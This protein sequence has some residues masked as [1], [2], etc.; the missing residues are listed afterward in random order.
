[1]AECMQLHYTRVPAVFFG[2]RPVF[3]ERTRLL[4]CA[5]GGLVMAW[6][7]GLEA[8]FVIVRG[9]EVDQ[10]V[11]P[12]GKAAEEPVAALA[13]GERILVGGSSRVIDVIRY[14]AV[15]QVGQVRRDVV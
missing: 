13:A 8:R 11:L 9:Q 10:G 6:E 14:L 7:R 4:M 5:A 1:M 3:H 15:G 2:S 12:G